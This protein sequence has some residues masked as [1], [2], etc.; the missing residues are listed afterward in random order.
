MASRSRLFQPFVP[1]KLIKRIPGTPGD[2]MVKGKLSPRSGFVVLRQLTP[3]IK[4]SHK[5]LYFSYKMRGSRGLFR[6][7]LKIF[8]VAFL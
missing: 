2:W 3:S 6:T 5:V 1:L 7:K 4:R 8:D